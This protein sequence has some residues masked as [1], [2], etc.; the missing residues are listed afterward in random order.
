MTKKIMKHRPSHYQT[1]D[2]TAKFTTWFCPFCKRNNSTM[3]CKV[4]FSQVCNPQIVC[5]IGSFH[6]E[7]AN[8]LHQV[9]CAF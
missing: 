3:L 8:G 9:F 7:W 4:L 5:R 2:A 6:A 1:E